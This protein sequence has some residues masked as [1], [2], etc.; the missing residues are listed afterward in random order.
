MFLLLRASP[1]VVDV[2]A[3]AGVP[4]VVDVPAVAGVP[5]VVDILAVA[6]VQ[7]IAAVWRHYNQTVISIIG[8]LT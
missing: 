6:S 2:L 1:S 7:P 5:S 4:A 8:Q 3:V